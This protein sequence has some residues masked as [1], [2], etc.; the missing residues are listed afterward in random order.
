MNT[1]EVISSQETERG[2]SD[3]VADEATAAIRTFNCELFGFYSNIEKGLSVHLASKHAKYSK[4]E[5][6]E[7]YCEVADDVIDKEIEEET[8]VAD[9]ESYDGDA[10]NAVD[11]IRR[12]GYICCTDGCI[13]EHKGV[14]CTMDLSV[15]L[16][17]VNVVM[18][19]V[20]ST[21]LPLLVMK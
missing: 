3:V 21:S 6:D 16:Q 11:K 7:S 15:K 13:A 14:I 20:K 5:A 9:E 2:S 17:S 12:P 19:T 10:A 4:I 8:R 18:T 1:E